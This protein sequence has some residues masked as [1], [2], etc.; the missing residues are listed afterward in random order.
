[1]QA[2]QI[3]QKGRQYWKRQTF[4]L[5]LFIISTAVG[6]LTPFLIRDFIDAITE[7]AGPLL[8]LALLIFVVGSLSSLTGFLGNYLFQIL[9]M[10]GVKDLQVEMYAKIQRTPVSSILEG[11]TGDIMS[12]I[13]SDTQIVGQIIAIG[14]PMLFLNIV[15]FSIVIVVLVLLDVKLSLLT[16]C[17]VPAYF[18]VFRTYNRRLRASTQKEREAFGRV[19]E[20]LREK[21]QGLITIKLFNAQDAYRDMFQEDAGF[22]FSRVKKRILNSTLSVNLIGYITRI[23]P[24]LVLLFGGYQVIAGFMTIGTL[25]GFWQYMGGLY[26]PIRNLAEWNNGLQQAVS[27]SQRIS[28]ILE[29]KE[30]M[31]GGEPLSK[32]ESIAISLKNVSFSYDRNKALENITCDIDFG[33]ITAVVGR[34]GGGKSTLINLLMGFYEPETGEILINNSR[35]QNYDL[36]SLRDVISYVRQK[37]F[38]FNTSIHKN[39]TLDQEFSQKK[40]VEAAQCCLVH[41]FSE[42]LPQ[43]YETRI[44]EKGFDLSDGQKQ[45]IALARALIREPQIL[46]LDE[47]TSAIDSENEAKI[48][49]NIRQKMKGTIIVVSH[50]LS[51]IKRAD[52]ILVLDAGQLVAEGNNETLKAESEVYGQLFKEQLIR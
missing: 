43:R 32:K 33:S 29:K 18:L 35:I 39:I 30:E 51:T 23:M 7:N 11:K 22:W 45:R 10:E 44:G 28:E 1:M 4:I 15:R 13:T 46:I 49:E 26:E 17:S 34:S 38:I 8:E 5:A 31:K 48:L 21:L 6:A 42:E 24:L 9:A 40:V 20:S 27:T 2:K 19:V 36:S 41:D 16:F 50:R 25:I 37:D 47:A 14:L 52:K 12:R 3:F